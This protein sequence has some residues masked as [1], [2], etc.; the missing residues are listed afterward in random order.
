MDNVTKGGGSS[1]SMGDTIADVVGIAM[2][3]VGIVS[4]LVL[5]LAGFSYATAAGD[6]AKVKKA[7]HMVIGGVV[8]LALAILAAVIVNI[9][10]SIK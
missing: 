6:E 9:T 2:W 7:K 4:V 5:V 8:G 10:L 3:A 1:Q